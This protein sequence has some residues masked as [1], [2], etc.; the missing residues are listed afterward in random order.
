MNPTIRRYL[1]VPIFLFLIALTFGQ[2]LIQVAQVVEV[3]SFSKDA[4]F[5]RSHAWAIDLCMSKEFELQ[6]TDKELGYCYVTGSIHYEASEIVNNNHRI[7]GPI[8]FKLKIYIR[9][10]R[11]KYV[12]YDF[13]HEGG[14]I[15]NELSYGLL[16]EGD[17]LIN[18]SMK[19][20]NMGVWVDIQHA[21]RSGAWEIIDEL[22]SAMLSPT[23]FEKD[24]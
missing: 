10:G 8:Y 24:W 12:F 13:F 3:S 19:R 14:D 6:Q 2:E 4:L 23:E 22:T 21:A 17:E 16:C 11:F 5:E 15:G 18:P 7:S 20:P 1:F 9:E